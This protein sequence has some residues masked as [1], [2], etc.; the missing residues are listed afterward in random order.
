MSVENATVITSMFTYKSRISGEPEDNKVICDQLFGAGVLWIEPIDDCLV[1]FTGIFHLSVSTLLCLIFRDKE[2][3]MAFQG[4]SSR[5]SR[6]NEHQEVSRQSHLDSAS[7]SHPLAPA[8]KILVND[9]ASNLGCA[10]ENALCVLPAIRDIHHSETVCRKP[11]NELSPSSSWRIHHRNSVD[12]TVRLHVALLCYGNIG[13]VTLEGEI[14]NLNLILHIERRIAENFLFWYTFRRMFPS[15]WNDYL[16]QPVFNL[17]IWIYN[18]WSDQNLGWSIVYLT[19]LLRLA[20]LPFTIVT[21]QGKVKNQELTEEVKRI[22]REFARDPILKKQEIRKV[23][24]KRQVYPWAKFISIGVQAV[25]FILLYQV[26]LRGITG[27]KIMK[28]LY[29]WIDFPGKINTF[30]YG[31]DLAKRFDIIFP[32]VVAIWLAV[33]I[34]VMMKGKIAKSSDLLYFFA[35]PGFV[36]VALWWLPAVKSLFILTSMAF[37]VIVHLFMKVILGGFKKKES[38]H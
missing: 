12:S 25:V 24:R 38:E 29:P 26:F 6:T 9:E 11:L 18:N 10:L 30:F 28:I 19:I 15:F 32:G 22:D 34:Y 3:D 7:E 13:K 14:V 33:E 37:S 36:F 1:Q 23:L 35:F 16:Y 21:E 27:D 31:F 5:F 8:S 20:L 4:F 17:L 2:I